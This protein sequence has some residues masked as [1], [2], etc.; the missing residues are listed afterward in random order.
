MHRGQDS[1][2]SGRNKHEVMPIM[3]HAGAIIRSRLSA[4]WLLAGLLSATMTSSAGG[5]HAADIIRVGKAA[6][7]TFAFAPIEIG[8]EKGIWAKYGLEVES[9]AFG[10]YVFHLERGELRTKYIKPVNLG[11]QQ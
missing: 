8:K 2:E 9:V 3:T 11:V 4:R 5:A 10:P 1:A 6:A 7:T